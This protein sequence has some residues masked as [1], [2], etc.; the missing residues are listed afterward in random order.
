MKF[1]KSTQSKISRRSPAISSLK[2]KKKSRDRSRGI[3]RSRENCRLFSIESSIKT[4]QPIN[5]AAI[6]P[7]YRIV[8]ALDRSLSRLATDVLFTLQFASR[9]FDDSRIEEEVN[10]SSRPYTV[11]TLRGKRVRLGAGDGAP[12]SALVQSV[13]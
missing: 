13:S 8:F 11:G 6:A 12:S 7:V 9:R 4:I 5:Y 3:E 2:K 1:Y 10:L